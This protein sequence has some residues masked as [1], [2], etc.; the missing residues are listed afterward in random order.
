MTTWKMQ[1]ER[2][3]LIKLP[4]VTINKIWVPAAVSTFD[5]VNNHVA[6]N[7]NL[8]EQKIFVVTLSLHVPSFLL[9][10]Y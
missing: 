4:H 2:G 1:G 6:T 7:S 3:N 10:D 5:G 9:Y 8:F